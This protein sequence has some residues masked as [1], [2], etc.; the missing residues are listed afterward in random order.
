MAIID[1]IQKGKRDGQ[2]SYFMYQP[3]QGINIAGLGEILLSQLRPGQRSGTKAKDKDEIEGTLGQMIDFDMEASQIS[4]DK[5][6]AV[7]KFLSSGD[8][9]TSNPDLIGGEPL[10]TYVKE[11]SRIRG[12]EQRHE[13]NR[14][15]L[16]QN[17][18]KRDE[19]VTASGKRGTSQNLFMRRNDFTGNIEPVA[20][21][22]DQYGKYE[23]TL[24][25]NKLDKNNIPIRDQYEM[26]PDI[27]GYFTENE[28]MDFQS[29][30]VGKGYD[31][32]GD[33]LPLETP[34]E[35]ETGSLSKKIIGQLDS[36]SDKFF[37]R[38]LSAVITK[39]QGLD[40]DF[41]VEADVKDNF[42][43]LQAAASNIYQSLSQ[44]EKTENS[45]EYHT[46][47]L[48]GVQILKPTGKKDKEGNFIVNSVP[49]Y[50]ITEE[51]FVVMKAMKLTRGIEEKIVSE[52]YQQITGT[53]GDDDDPYGKM[54]FNQMV[55][56]T[57]F[58]VET[59]F[60]QSR[61][62]FTADQGDVKK[63]QN[64]KASEY[65]PFPTYSVELPLESVKSMNAA[66][67]PSGLI[68]ESYDDLK[69][70]NLFFRHGLMPDGQKI[71]FR[72]FNDLRIVRISSQLEHAPE[73][74]LDPGGNLT[75]NMKFVLDNNGDPVQ[76]TVP[77]ENGDLISIDN[78]YL[79]PYITAW[80][81]GIEKEL[82]GKIFFPDAEDKKRTPEGTSVALEFKKLKEVS[83]QYPDI[84]LMSESLHGK[85]GTPGKGLWFIKNEELVMF[86]VRIPVPTTRSAEYSSPDKTTP[87]NKAIFR[88]V[89]RN[90]EIR[91]TYSNS[92][93]L[94]NRGAIEGANPKNTNTG[95]GRMSLYPVEFK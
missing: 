71:I 8:V 70:I 31:R 29:S 92:A 76:A 24:Y 10:D 39:F 84:R 12:L 82:Q 52:D 2:P 73:F 65:V 21:G 42:D 19:A 46:A 56:N 37:G 49:V 95:G 68:P 83:N 25:T 20:F 54:S 51:D 13:R 88:N 74:H 18:K 91:N 59:G 72:D 80:I 69:D 63:G 27:A 28:Y 58:A 22:I 66:I 9:T 86:P 35:Y 48:Q 4:S 41:V 75:N 67:Y 33:A 78:A 60:Q 5:R 87:G 47:A 16:K 45:M 43:Q 30:A 94:K 90:A 44:A 89:F 79:T 26:N 50:D 34:I 62:Y 40:K 11:M 14:E 81:I 77:D 38:P 55:N 64:I 53:G 57:G 85:S 93:N 17:V 3:G 36:A 32:Y 61:N 15:M 1:K 7:E 23:T 6:A